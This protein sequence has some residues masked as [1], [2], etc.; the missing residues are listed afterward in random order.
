MLLFVIDRPHK[1]MCR[2]SVLRFFLQILSK[3]HLV[4]Q[5]IQFSD[6][7]PVDRASA[8][9]SVGREFEFGLEPKIFPE[10]IT[11]TQTKRADPS[12]ILFVEKDG[13]YLLD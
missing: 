6:G 8:C 9:K 7:G 2:P 1:F 10:T 12:R 4:I 5:S 3:I 11:P 13:D